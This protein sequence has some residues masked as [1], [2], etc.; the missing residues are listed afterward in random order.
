MKNYFT[1]L[2]LLLSHLIFA[3]QIDGGV[4]TIPRGRIFVISVGINQNGFYGEFRNCISDA[5]LLIQTIAKQN[6]VNLINPNTVFGKNNPT[7][8]I[9]ND[10]VF[11]HAQLLTEMQATKEN[12][13]NAIN[14]VI[15]LAMPEDYF[16][17]SFAGVSVESKFDPSE[18]YFLTYD[19]NHSGVVKDDYN[20]SLRWAIA[21][22]NYAINTQE[23][24]DLFE[25]IQARNQLFI[26]ESGFNKDFP[27]LFVK[28]VLRS[29]MQVSSLLSKNRVFL[30][31][32]TIGLD[33]YGNIPHGPLM[34]FISQ[35]TNLLQVFTTP[36]RVYVELLTQ[37]LKGERFSGIYTTLFSEKSF[38]EDLFYI[39]PDIQHLSRGPDM[40][41][42]HTN[43]RQ[44]ISG[45]HALLIATDHY[46]ANS[47][48]STLS[49]PVLDAV[50]IGNVLRDSYG[51][52]TKILID[53]SANS[54]YRNIMNYA[55]TLDSNAQLFIF[56]A[57][58]GYYNDTYF[59]E[60]YIVCKESKSPNADPY[61]HSYIPFSKIGKMINKI[62]AKQIFVVFDVCFGGA[63]NNQISLC[64]NRNETFGSN[65]YQQM[66]HDEYMS[67]KLKKITR[68]FLTSGG[69][70]EVPDGYKGKS[71]P[72]ALRLLEALR[73]L[74][75]SYFI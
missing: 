62:P 64:Q 54:I 71:S 11:F 49:N 35:T 56:F 30:L 60:G 68:R 73:S 59:D 12:I 10:S 52:Q 36:Q 26:T 18:N 46:D 24:K 75:G 38:Y 7:Y 15:E 70:E 34:Y 32:S 47:V 40:V 17:F 14:N 41:S 42:Q 33:Q 27:K 31:P 1:F 74:G 69:K 20:D 39:V 65:I 25:L 53:S 9:D 3:K 55:S 72:F 13:L 50:S 29:N 67:K 43:I 22:K 37:E 2:L 44:T 63:F 66:E 23:I 61:L 51:F 58:H 48:W 4:D 16:I 5:Q 19:I 28:K 45:K 57:G 21:S 6:K 8:L